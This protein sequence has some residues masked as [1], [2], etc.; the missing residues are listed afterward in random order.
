MACRHGDGSGAVLDVERNAV[1]KHRVSADGSRIPLLAT[2][3]GEE[4]LIAWQT[5]RELAAAGGPGFAHPLQ[6]HS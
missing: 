2:P 5:M 4:W 3:T 6:S 1:G